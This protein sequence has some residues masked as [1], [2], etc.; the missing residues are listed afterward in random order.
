MDVAFVKSKKSKMLQTTPI[1]LSSHLLK[2]GKK[3]TDP[4]MAVPQHD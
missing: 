2:K 4:V 3:Y 1:V